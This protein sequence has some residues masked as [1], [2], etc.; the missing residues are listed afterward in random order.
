[1]M[2][3]DSL[4][5]LLLDV[6]MFPARDQR[7]RE[8]PRQVC[9][10]AQVSSV[11]SVNLCIYA[12]IWTCPCVQKDTWVRILAVVKKTYLQQQA[13]EADTGFSRAGSVAGFCT[14]RQHWLMWLPCIMPDTLHV[15]C[16]HSSHETHL[17]SSKQG[18]PLLPAQL[19]LMSLLLIMFCSEATGGL[20]LRCTFAH[21]DLQTSRTLQVFFTPLSQSLRLIIH[22]G[23]PLPEGTDFLFDFGALTCLF[24]FSF[25]LMMWTN[26]VGASTGMFVPALAV[27]AVGVWPCPSLLSSTSH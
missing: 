23:E 19:S 12:R 14:T 2:Q 15:C 1:M 13:K 3:H 22:L 4:S 25:I 9:E 20:A 5:G 18:V 16:V 7:L 21:S 17:H 11:V 27:G 24:L 6:S 10:K 8:K 26:G